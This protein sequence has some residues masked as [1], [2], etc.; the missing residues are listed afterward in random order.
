MVCCKRL[1]D[2]DDRTALKL[3]WDQL[4]HFS[5][6]RWWK[7]R[8][9]AWVLPSL[10]GDSKSGAFE[11]TFLAIML[12]YQIVYHGYW[13]ISSRWV[14]RKR[15]PLCTQFLPLGPE[16]IFWMEPTFLPYYSTAIHAAAI[17][18]YEVHSSMQ[19]NCVNQGRV[20]RNMRGGAENLI[21]YHPSR[22]ACSWP[23]L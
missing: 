10:L 19:E 2:R 17:W 20:A 6:F 3:V 7:N 22:D 21:L 16:S 15:L 18:S 1:T 13:F 12:S 4:E 14:V 5:L 11:V 8:S 9:A 23:R